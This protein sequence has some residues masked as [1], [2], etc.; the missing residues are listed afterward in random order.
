MLVARVCCLAV[1]CSFLPFAARAVDYGGQQTNS[2][3]N[4]PVTSG[5]P[6]PA[7]SF[8]L[9]DSNTSLTGN[10]G[11]LAFGTGLS[12]GFTHEEGLSGKSPGHGNGLYLSGN[13]GPAALGFGAE[14]IQY[15]ASCTYANPCPRRLSYG[16]GLRLAEALGFGVTY[17]TFS[18]ASNLDVDRLSS[19]DLGLLARFNRYLTGGLAVLD[20]NAPNSGLQLLPRRYVLSLGARPL[21]EVATLGIDAL[22]RSCVDTTFTGPKPCGLGHPDLF[23]TLDARIVTGVHFVGQVGAFDS[24]TGPLTFQA[25]LQIDL[26]R[27]TLRAAPRFRED[28]SPR[29]GFRVALSSAG[30]P[31]F[32]PIHPRR[33]VEIDLGKLLERPTPGPLDLLFGQRKEDPLARVLSLLKRLGKDP[34]VRAV[35]FKLDNLPFGMARA[36]ELRNGIEELRTAGKKLLFYLESGGDLEYYV[37]STADRV[38]AAPQAV[39]AVNGFSATAFFAAAGLDKLGVK[40]E[41][42]RVGAYKNAPDLFTRSEMSSEQREAEGALLDDLF[43]RYFRALIEK[44]H[45][46]PAKLKALLDQGLVKPKEAVDAGLLDGLIYPDQLEE[47]VGKLVGAKVSLEKASLEAPSV[48][49]HGWGSLPRIVVIRVEGDILRGEGKKAPF[50]AVEVAGSD[51]IAR[52]IRA[53]ADDSDVAAIVVRIESPGGDGNASDL[54]WRELVRARKEKKKPVVASMGD[55]AA[56]GGYYVAAGADEI[57]AEPSTVTGSIGVFVGHFDAEELLGKLGVA[58]TTMNRGAS[59][60]L[61][62]PT[63]DLT[64]AERKMFQSWVDN[65]YQDFLERV[66]E[67]RNM[68]KDEVDK[69]GRGR[70]WTGAQALERRLVDRL[71][72]LEDAIASAKRRAGLRLDDNVRIDDEE[73]GEVDLQDLTLQSSLTPIK[74]LQASLPGKV[75]QEAARALVIFGE[76]GTVRARLP[77]DLEVR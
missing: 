36:E 74:A 2:N 68:S 59:A 43:G 40:A 3:Q 23:L 60:D 27:A 5:V 8:A 46:E 15:G 44:R 63:R 30:G 48:R 69:V 25:G 61:F 77:F 71:G 70:I 26:G 6:Q 17:H 62:S 66:A 45:L 39:L 31:S 32:A 21:G 50:G 20:V 37:A 53:A 49:D 42:F 1:V 29:G 52:R 11:G 56:S 54:I 13:L 35:A 58:T 38:F 47:E 33:A 9:D 65:F 7:R 72:G 10:P 64:F 75:F 67:G 55:V 41:F 24:S 22:V 12:L 51:S 4:G 16:L 57:L 19:V 34:G 14:W 28:G 18:D 76:P 73:R